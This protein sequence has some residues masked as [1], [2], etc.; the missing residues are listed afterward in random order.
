[1]RAVPRLCELYPGLCLT[2]EE[3]HRKTSVRVAART[4]QADTV[5]Y[6]N[7]EQYNTQKKNTSSNKQYYKVTEQ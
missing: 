2:T 6:K 3:K 1:V 5:Q 7:N 4:S